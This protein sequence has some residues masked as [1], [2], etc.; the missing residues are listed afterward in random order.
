ML[1]IPR[2]TK[3]P[4]TPGI[5]YVDDHKPCKYILPCGLCTYK[6]E[7][8]KAPTYCGKMGDNNVQNRNTG[9]PG[10]KEE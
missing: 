4:P 8:L 6:T 1:T 5:I 3:R 10:H 9:E 2:P 7:L